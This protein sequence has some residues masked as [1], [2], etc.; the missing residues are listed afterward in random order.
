[1]L[2]AINFQNCFRICHHEGSRNLGRTEIEWSIC[3]AGLADDV[4]A[5]GENLNA[6]KKQQKSSVRK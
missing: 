4:N 3:A 5:V 2:Y 6:I 1:M